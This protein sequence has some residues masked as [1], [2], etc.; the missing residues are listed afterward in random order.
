MLTAR[1]ISGDLVVTNPKCKFRI[2]GFN[3]STNLVF[4]IFTAS[5]FGPKVQL[6]S[7]SL[8]I[9]GETIDFFEPSNNSDDGFCRFEVWDQNGNIIQKFNNSFLVL[10]KR[11]EGQ[12]AHNHLYAINYAE[13]FFYNHPS[14]QNYFSTYIANVINIFDDVWEKQVNEWALNNGSDPFNNSSWYYLSLNPCQNYSHYLFLFNGIDSYGF[15]YDCYQTPTNI[16]EIG[17]T[18]NPSL[19]LS[20]TGT[21]YTEEEFIRTALHHEFY[22]GIQYSLS[23]NIFGLPLSD[24]SKVQWII[25]GQARAIQTIGEP[26]AEFRTR[27]SGLYDIDANRYIF[28]DL[29]ESLLKVSYSYGIFWRYIYENYKTSNTI[30]DKIAIFRQTIENFSAITLPMLESQ[31]D[32]KLLNGGGTICNMDDAVIGF[33]KHILFNDPEFNMWNPC[34][35]NEFYNHIP[36]SNIVY[37]S[38]E[39]TISNK[40]NSSFG[41]DYIQ[42]LFKKSGKAFINFNGDP[43][44]DG[45]SPTYSVKVFFLSAPYEGIVVPVVNGIGTLELS[46]VQDNTTAYVIVIRLDNNESLN[47]RYGIRVG[48]TIPPGVINASFSVSSQRSGGN[49]IKVNSSVSFIDLSQSSNSTI[50]NWSWTFSGGEPTTSSA[51]NP[52]NIQYNDPGTY[53]VSLTVNNMVGQEDT[54]TINGYIIVYEEGNSNNNTLEFTANNPNYASAGQTVML[55]VQVLTGTPPFRVDVYETSMTQSMFEQSDSFSFVFPYTW[56]EAGLKNIKY[57]VRDANGCSGERNLSISIG[58]PGSQIVNISHNWTSSYENIVGTLSNVY[59]TDQTTGGYQPFYKWE[60][61]YGKGLNHKQLP[62][63]AYNR[64]W[65]MRVNLNNDLSFNGSPIYPVQFPSFDIY[66]ITLIVTDNA[67]FQVEKTYYLEVSEA[68]KCFCFKPEWLINYDFITKKQIFDYSETHYGGI[69]YYSWIEAYFPWAKTYPNYCSSEFP[70]LLEGNTTHGSLNNVITNSKFTI[71]RD[72]IVVDT[73]FDEMN[74]DYISNA[75]PSPSYGTPNPPNF[76]WT[77]H[78]YYEYWDGWFDFYFDPCYANMYD[79]PDWFEYLFPSPGI[80]QL[81]FEAW[82]KIAHP[83]SWSNNPTNSPNLEMYNYIDVPLYVIDCG[84]DEDVNVNITPG[85][86]DDRL[87]GIIK[88]ANLAPVSI[89]NGA[90]ITYQSC[91]YIE[92]CKNNSFLAESGSVFCATVFDLKADKKE[93]WQKKSLYVNGTETL[94]QHTLFC[95]PNPNHGVFKLENRLDLII[96]NIQVISSMGQV[97]QCNFESDFNNNFIVHITNPKPGMFFVKVT[98]TDAEAKYVKIVVI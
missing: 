49:L 42:V 10:Y 51:Q 66:P 69:G 82:N 12:T 23:K 13:R 72:G 75:P 98:F 96:E 44:A 15:L 78:G 8:S 34:P 87:G 22:H 9:D 18:A 91:N 52:V 25:E 71:S 64:S 47:E 1:N 90:I 58:L 16:R 29:N 50:D 27:S 61:V 86:Y 24:F 40:I 63:N 57:S 26:N 59:F 65:E 67:G 97:F 46:I 94:R 79:E 14:G 88:F 36:Q 6:F 2:I 92:I 85:E 68:T 95:Y 93:Q 48:P 53:S 54:K 37:E 33:S 45:L 89:S 70:Y 83:N 41:I 35:S 21:Q 80:Y 7:S 30:K 56:N 60:W 74:S 32:S 11:N 77:S 81:R 5:E 43:N 17:F 3:H 38:D 31:I 20:G 76:N 28:D 19:F 62:I 84:A 73:H 55:T 39:Q 4:K